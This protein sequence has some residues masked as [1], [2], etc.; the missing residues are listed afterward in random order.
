MAHLPGGTD[1]RFSLV[2]IAINPEYAQGPI[3]E[4]ATINLEESQLPVNYLSNLVNWHK[5][6]KLL[7]C[8]TACTVSNKLTFFLQRLKKI[9]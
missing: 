9:N 8:Q 4:E 2:L 6:Q 1:S 5:E 7:K 3:S